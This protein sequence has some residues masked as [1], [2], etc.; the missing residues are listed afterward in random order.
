MVTPAFAIPRL[1]HDV[2]VAIGGWSVGFPQSVIESYD[3]R[4]DRWVPIKEEDP[5]GARS[6]H[7][8]GVIENKIYCI[9]GFDGMEHFNTCRML[10]LITKEWKEVNILK[11]LCF[12]LYAN[13]M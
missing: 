8:T 3:T 1:P 11:I 10:N 13:G 9:G 12:C 2:I 4:A 5:G 7:G 6:Y